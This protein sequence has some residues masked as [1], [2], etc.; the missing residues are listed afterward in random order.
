MSAEND[1][2]AVRHKDLGRLVGVDGSEE[3]VNG[4]GHCRYILLALFLVEEEELPVAVAQFVGGGAS[5]AVLNPL[6][7]QRMVR[8]W[9]PAGHVIVDWLADF[10][11]QPL[12]LF[13]LQIKVEKGG[14]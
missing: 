3:G 2:L 6:V 4:V 8:G 12:K 11:F 9:D 10:L 13:N 14:S 7:G 5:R 1:E